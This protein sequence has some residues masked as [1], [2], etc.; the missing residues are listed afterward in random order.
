MPRTR[1][2]SRFF[3]VT[4]TYE[5]ALL[6]PCGSEE[7]DAH[8]R[9]LVLGRVEHFLGWNRLDARPVH[10]R[11]SGPPLPEPKA[12][13]LRTDGGSKL[14]KSRSATLRAHQPED[15]ALAESVFPLIL[16]S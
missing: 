13:L 5:T 10:K 3:L 8:L 1:H 2:A 16:T 11:Q 9:F 4:R 15:Q 6:L 12:D 14:D 7:S